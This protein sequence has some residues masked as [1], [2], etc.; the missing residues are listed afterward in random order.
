MEPAYT[1]AQLEAVLL[2]TSREL[3]NDLR[4]EVLKHYKTAQVEYQA[5]QILARAEA[6]RVAAIRAAAE[7]RRRDRLIREDFRDIQR[8]RNWIQQLPRGEQMAAIATN[9]RSLTEWRRI[10]YES[11]QRNR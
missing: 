1:N 8:A 5:E 3:P 9:A 11:R 6:E 7:E 2:A 10:Q 4:R